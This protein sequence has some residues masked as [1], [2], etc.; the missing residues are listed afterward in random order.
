MLNKLVI[1]FLVSAVIGVSISYS[2]IYLFHI[3]YLSLFIYLLINIKKYQIKNTIIA[4]YKYLLFFVFFLL[5]YSISILW[6]ISPTMYAF[7]YLV[8]IVL[9][10]SIVSVLVIFIDSKDKLNIVFKSLGFIFIVEIILSLLE[11]LPNFRL[12]IS[13]HSSIVEYFGREGNNI[14]TMFTVPT[15]FNWNHNDFSV[16]MVLILP[17]FLFHKNIIIKLLFT[18]CIS[19]LVFK[20]GSRGGLLSLLFIL[21]LYFI[22]NK[23]RFFIMLITLIIVSFTIF[24]SSYKNKVITKISALYGTMNTFLV[25]TKSATG[26]ILIRQRLII[27]GLDALKESQYLG[28]GIGGNI[29]VQKR[30]GGVYKNLGENDFEHISRRETPIYSMHSFLIEIL[31][32]A[33]LVFFTIFMAWYFYIIYTLYKMTKINDESLQYFAKASIFSM[34]AFVLGSVTPSSMIYMLPMWILFGFALSVIKVGKLKNYE[35]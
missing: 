28:V 3:S 20:T 16:V 7:K 32:D 23:K 11:T 30:L 2:K 15:G 19:Y 21:G 29:E 1:F 33:G 9:G 14:I 27:N 35:N 18:L 13:P 25:D 24:Q 10:L 22:T 34:F 31:V 4:N 26:S 8:Y 5:W 12:P 17:F 6:T